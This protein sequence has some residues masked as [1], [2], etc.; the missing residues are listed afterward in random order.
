MESIQISCPVTVKVVMTPAVRQRF[1]EE[2]Q[3]SIQMLD[4]EIEKLEGLVP[5]TP[6]PEADLVRQQIEAQKARL[7]QRRGELEWHIREAQAVADGAELPFRSYQGLVEL[8]VGDDFLEKA[9]ETEVIL[10]DWQVVAI[11]RVS[12]R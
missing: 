11:R 8:R 3:N 2:A 10:K 4:A 9:A 6:S 7:L 1:V 12:S 5:Q